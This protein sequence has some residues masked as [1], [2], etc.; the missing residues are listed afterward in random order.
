[1][2]KIERDRKALKASSS[3]YKTSAI[4]KK[5]IDFNYNL[6]MNRMIRNNPKR[7]HPTRRDYVISKIQHNISNYNQPNGDSK[8]FETLLVG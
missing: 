6:A 5:V 4:P 8:Q 2:D 3:S 7:D 1:M